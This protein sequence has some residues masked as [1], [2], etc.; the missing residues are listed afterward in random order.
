MTRRPRPIGWLRVPGLVIW[1]VV[2]WVLLWGDLSVANVV[3]GVAV[4][5]VIVLS[6]R[7]VSAGM[8]VPLRVRPLA[9]VR[10]AAHFLVALVRANLVL[11]WEILTPRNRIHTGIIATRRAASADGTRCW[12]HTTPPLPPR[13]RPAPTMA[14]AR[15]ATAVGASP[16]RSPRRM[17]K[18]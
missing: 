15:H 7:N 4:A 6:T 9:A 10:F 13:S 12:A 8:P 18:V 11:A 2:L 16:C 17:A 1:L 5:T 14:A 3:G